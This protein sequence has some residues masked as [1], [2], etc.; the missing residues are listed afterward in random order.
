MHT[1]YYPDHHRHDPAQLHQPNNARQNKLLGEVAQ[2]GRILYEAVTAA[3][4]G[5]ITPPADFGLEV[6]SDVHAYGMLNLL[7]DGYQRMQRE[8]GRPVTVADT[9][10]PRSDLPHKPRSILGLLGYYMFDT[11]AP[12]LEHTWEAAYW[13]AQTAV[14]A[15]ALV[16]AGDKLAYAL[17]RPPGHHAG[18]MAQATEQVDGQHGDHHKQHQQRQDG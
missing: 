13:A 17:T 3:K 4:L 12:L 2:R 15:A 16:T 10:N 7:R 11:Y 18:A 1:F 8:I 6:I 9:F 14:S 5:P